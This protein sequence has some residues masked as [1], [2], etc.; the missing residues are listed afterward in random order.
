MIK[1]TLLA[2]GLWLLSLAPTMADTIHVEHVMMNGPVKMI[3]PFATDS[4]N[5]KG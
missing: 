4:V 5:Q 1:K 2:C 3:R